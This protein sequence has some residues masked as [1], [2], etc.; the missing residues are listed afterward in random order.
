MMPSQR[1]P[2]TQRLAGKALHDRLA[3]DSVALDCLLS[4]LAGIDVSGSAS[5]DARFVVLALA[6]RS[7]CAPGLSLPPRLRRVAALRAVT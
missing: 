3:F 2:E 4:L 7:C 5:L 1:A 6:L